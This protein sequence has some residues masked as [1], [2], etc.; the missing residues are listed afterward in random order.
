M[1]DRMAELKV[2]MMVVPTVST[3]V[4]PTVSLTVV[5]MV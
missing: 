2:A 5:M 4:V 1:V 3:M